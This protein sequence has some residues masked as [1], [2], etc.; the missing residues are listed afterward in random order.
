MSITTTKELK[1][2]IDIVDVI[3]SAVPLKRAG[4]N[5][6]CC[7]PF[8]G[9]KTPSFKVSRERQ[10]Y[11]CFGCGVHGDAI[12]FVQK[13]YNI[14]FLD[15]VNKLALDNGLALD[16][17]TGKKEDLKKYYEA[18]NFAAKFFY[19]AFIGRSNLAYKYMKDR[20]ISDN[21]LKKFG[22]GYADDSWDSL[23]NYLL[24]KGVEKDV[25][26]TLGLSSQGKKGKLYDKFRNR[27]MFPII[28]TSKKV[29]GFGG[30][31]INKKDAPKY[32][33]SMESP[34]F[35]KKDNLYAL[36]LAQNKIREKKEIILVEGYMDVI[37]LFQA[38]IDN[39]C[40]SL[41]TALTYDQGKLIKKYTK[42]VILCYDFD[43]AGIN[44]SI[45]GIDVLRDSGTKP[46]VVTNIDSLDAKDPDEYIKKY[47]KENFERL[48]KEASTYEEFNIIMSKRNLDLKNSD[49]V[50][51]YLKRVSKILL[52]FNSLEREIYQE[53]IAKELGISPKILLDSIEEAKNSKNNNLYEDSDKKYREYEKEQ[54]KV[55]LKKSLNSISN[56]EKELLKL[57]YCNKE[58]ID[59]LIGNE[60][61][62]ESIASRYI[63]SYLRDKK[64]KG[65][66]FTEENVCNGLD[67][68]YR[69]CLLHIIKNVPLGDDKD[70]ILMEA[71]TR[72]QK[73]LL[74][75]ESKRILNRIYLIENKQGYSEEK[76][77][78]M[79][80][81]DKIQNQISKKG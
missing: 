23:T 19:N 66:R 37:S 22:I 52:G 54:N 42:N 56:I 30:R 13:Y 40:A 53:K 7:C 81:L 9:E 64:N 77:Q 61:V 20:N 16:L 34:V 4:R 32:L 15:A 35:K 48:I 12:E 76:K 27:V 18:N 26:L 31:V 67:S 41:G 24:S 36:N 79:K 68:P 47:G 55:D 75:K 17:K 33:N 21:I 69:E 57:I 25:L 46:K 80:R 29:I 65:I 6:E 60:N 59:G 63:F 45:K 58:Y 43:T 10:S 11:H 49:H 51:T 74:K 73:D 38:G 5:Y 2:Q 50:L 62:F 71:I 28:N 39:V 78:L 72:H 44:A 1:S 8:H 70:L 3:N 14:D